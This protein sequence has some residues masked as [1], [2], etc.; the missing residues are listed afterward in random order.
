MTAEYQTRHIS[1]WPKL[2]FAVVCISPW[3]CSAAYAQKGMGDQVGVVRRGLKPP[4]TQLSGKIVSIE[5]HPCEKTTGPALAGTHLIV[6]GTDGKQYNL[7]LGPASAVAPIVEPL[8][9]DKQIEVVAFRTSQMPANQYVATTLRL[10]GGKV[11]VLRDSDLRP[12][13]SRRTGPGGGS[14]RGLSRYGQG[15]GFGRQSRC[16]STPHR[17]PWCGSR[18]GSGRC[19]F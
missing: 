18:R 11:L 19:I 10:E 14:N 16:Q 17:G 5:T 8:Q 1:A 15:R 6:E 13:W 4:M 12:F 9:P 3:V 2:L 7:H